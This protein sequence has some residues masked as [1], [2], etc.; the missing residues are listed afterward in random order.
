MKSDDESSVDDPSVMLRIQDRV[1]MQSGPSPRRF[2]ISTPGTKRIRRQEAAGAIESHGD[3]RKDTRGNTKNGTLVS[4]GNTPSIPVLEVLFCGIAGA[5]LYCLSLLVVGF[6]QLAFLAIAPWAWLTLDARRLG[7]L[8]GLLLWVIGSMMWLALELGQQFSWGSSETINIWLLTYL[9]LYLPVFVYVGRWSRMLLHLPTYIVLPIIWCASEAIR[10]QLF[11]GISIGLLAHA[12]AESRR[13]IQVVDLLGSAGLS[14]VMVATGA[15]VAELIW[16]SRRLKGLVQPDSDL[17][18]DTV[19]QRSL[20]V[21]ASPATKRITASQKSMMSL[22][23]RKREQT[24]DVHLVSGVCSLLLLVGLLVFFNTYGKRRAS[25]S[26]TW[27]MFDSYL[28][29]TAVFTGENDSRLFDVLAAKPSQSL[30]VGFFAEPHHELPTERPLLIVDSAQD[31]NDAWRLTRSGLKIDRKQ[32]SLNP[33]SRSAAKQILGLGQGESLRLMG[34]DVGVP[35]KIL[36]RGDNSFDLEDTV[37]HILQNEHGNGDWVDLSMI[38]IDE[39]VFDGTRWPSLFLRSVLSAS[40][41]NRVPV[42]CS[43]PGKVCVVANGDGGLW[44]SA[45]GNPDEAFGNP[46]AEGQTRPH[47]LRVH[48]LMDPR[49]SLFVSTFGRYPKFLAIIC[50]AV[51]VIWNVVQALIRFRMSFGSVG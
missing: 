34:Q 30:L 18:G 4:I 7:I 48:A 9:G 45:S 32:F 10:C 15:S 3:T 27:K 23:R 49:S 50:F 51:I 43:I 46:V 12:A 14:L 21:S 2:P 5:S 17:A 11:G 6:G 35:L 40:I 1:G 33:P 41:A 8:R 37:N 38:V 47:P 13:I 42:I 19:N 31:S 39:G 26:S 25:E 20:F 24:R 29:E 16:V 22:L 36:I 28:Y 44:W